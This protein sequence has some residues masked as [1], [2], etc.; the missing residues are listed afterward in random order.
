MSD[1]DSIKY[2]NNFNKEHYD[3]INLIM[4]KGEK[5]VIQQHAKASG[6]SVSEYIRQAV[7]ERMEK[8][9]I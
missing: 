5:E 3:R 2:S 4:P 6:Q 1:F 8:E 7:S 9:T